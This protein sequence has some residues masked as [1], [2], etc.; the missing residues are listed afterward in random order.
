MLGRVCS[1]LHRK[2]RGDL[3]MEEII[4]KK[5]KTERLPIISLEATNFLGVGRKRG[6]QENV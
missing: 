6:A 5:K 3:K 4:K 2:G 1:P